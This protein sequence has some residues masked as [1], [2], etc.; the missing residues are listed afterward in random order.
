MALSPA[1][2]AVLEANTQ[3]LNNHAAILERTLRNQP[4][5]DLDPELV[6]SAREFLAIPSVSSRPM[7][8][9]ENLLKL[10]LEA[11]HSGSTEDE[12]EAVVSVAL[13]ADTGQAPP[14]GQIPAVSRKSAGRTN[15]LWKK[16]TSGKF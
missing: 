5:P 10:H 1:D 12:R 9:K 7:A 6:K 2:R 14:T 4:A 8:E 13:I 16:F 11:L 3:A 15:K